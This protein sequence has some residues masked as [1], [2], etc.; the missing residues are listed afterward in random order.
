M[1][2]PILATALMLCLAA[3]QDDRA[4][5]AR[6]PDA[7]PSPSAQAEGAAPAGDPL[8]DAL[9]QGVAIDFPYHFIKREDIPASNGKEARL[10]YTLEYL[11]GDAASVT[12]SLAGSM[13][14]AGFQSGRWQARGDGRIHFAANKN[15]YG[16]MQANIIPLSKSKPRNAA[17]K[18]S[19]TL[20]WPVQDAP[21]AKAI[22]AQASAPA[23]EQ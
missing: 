18:G 15:G 10:R 22:D 16:Q 9:P 7:Q 21:A 8:P 19:V 14:E 13:M 1:K 4:P 6:T 2:N 5:A 20:G 11:E 12:A 17:A 3:C 23:T